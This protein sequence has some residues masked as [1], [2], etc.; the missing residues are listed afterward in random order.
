[1]LFAILAV[2]IRVSAAASLTDALQAI[3]SRYPAASVVFNFGASGLLARQIMEGAP[4]DVFISADEPSMDRLEQRGL[5]VARS[6]RTILSNRLVVIIPADSRLRI[7]SP[8]DLLSVRGVAIASPDSTPAGVYAQAYLRKAGVWDRIA[9]KIIPTGNVRSALAA[10]ESGNVETGI[11]YK[12]DA[13]ISRSVRIAYEV[14][15]AE[16][17]RISY[18]AAVIADSREKAAALRFLDFLQS[19][20]AREIFRRAGFILP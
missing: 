4:A 16:G 6:R 3:A 7:A 10:V 5:I 17:P 19:A 9:P 11:V 15:P 8:R 20:Q 12:T 14:P 18:P 1:M 2:T 13:L